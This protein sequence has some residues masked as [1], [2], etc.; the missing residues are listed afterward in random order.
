M[1]DPKLEEVFKLSGVPTYTFVEPVEYPK[2]MVALRTPGRGVLIEG[3]S[4]IG[5]TTAVMKALGELGIE[6]TALKLSA[7]KRDDRE[8]IS[9][10]PNTPKAGLVIIDDFHRLEPKIQEGI[11]DHLKVLADE[12]R[13]DTKAD[14]CRH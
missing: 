8:L 14:Y 13:L 12:E 11:A 7:R 4:G 5:K 3:P 6:A 1:P 10:L 2:L 9:E